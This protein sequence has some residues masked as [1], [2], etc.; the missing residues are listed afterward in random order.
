MTS[1]PE[2][3]SWVGSETGP[4]FDDDLLRHVLDSHGV[5]A[6]YQPLV[7]LDDGRIVA[8]ESLARG[9]IG[10]ALEQPD[11]LF[12]AARRAGRVSDL[13]A[14]CRLAAVAGARA[15]GLAAPYRLFVNAEPEALT[16]WEPESMH[17]QGDLPITVVVELTERALAARPAELLQAVAR[18]RTLGWGVALDDVGAVPESLA[19]L[20]MLRPDV[21]KLDMRLVQQRATADVAAVMNA[22]HA[23]AER[24]GTVI[25]AEGLETKEHVQTARAFGATLGQGWFF[26]RPGPLVAPLPPFTGRPVVILKHDSHE[27]HPSPFEH[28]AASRTARQAVKPLLIEVS[29]QLEAQARHAGDSAVV[30]SSFQSAQFFTTD[31]IRR[32]TD[33]AEHTAFVGALGEGMSPEPCP[34]VRGAV[35]EDDDPVRGEWDIAVLGPHFSA[36]LV[37]RDLG[38]DGPDRN[39]RFEFVLSHDRELT[40]AVANSLMSRIWPEPRRLDPPLRT[41][42]A[43]TEALAALA[44]AAHERESQHVLGHDTSIPAEV[45]PLILERA[46]AA[47]TAGITVADVRDPRHPLIWVNRAFT[48]LTGYTSDDVLGRNCRFLQGPATDPQVVSDM[49]SAI[50]DGRELRVLLRN[51]RKDG[52]WWWNEVHLSPV[53]GDGGELTHYIGVQN[54]VTSRVEA[55]EK[56]MQMAYNDALTGLPNRIR[57]AERMEVSLARGRAHDRCTGLLFIDLDNFKHVNDQYGHTAGDDLLRRVAARLRSVVRA[58]DLL[59]RHGG[60]EFLVLLSD[61]APESAR[62]VVGRVAASMTEA[63]QAPFDIPGCRWTVQA[64]IGTS[65]APHDGQT[66]DE[67]LGRAD[68][69]MYA[70]KQTRDVARH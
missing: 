19:L 38:D 9:P 18:M 8:F 62:E 63:L 33:L 32:Y 55:E 7:D 44:A 39:R 29:K 34:G 21:I 13:D 49:R 70:V 40:I 61:L 60:D 3:V 68:S 4:A 47:A 30:L 17:A 11:A 10:S 65:V 41:P 24:S 35:L 26:G 36:T 23:E 64:S 54:D 66:A 50:A 56:I 59:A 16:A 42:D 20:P 45:S 15:A 5:R 14:A 12:G 27:P 6:T 43:Q 58:E 37:A 48:D 22:V 52:T 28:V 1:A 69:A 25:L 2:L 51:L 53:I 46:L 67:L 31:T 57:L